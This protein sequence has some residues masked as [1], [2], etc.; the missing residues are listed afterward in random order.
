MPARDLAPPEPRARRATPVPPP[1]PPP[2][3]A[4]PTARPA[5][6][7]GAQPGVLVVDDSATMRRVFEITL[8]EDCVVT[9]VGSGSEA[10]EAARAMQPDLVIADLSLADK[11]GYQICAEL[12]GDAG[13]G[14]VPVLL[15]HGPA[16]QYDAGRAQQVQATDAIAK[17]FGT[18]ELLDKVLE[19]AS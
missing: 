13:L 4:A 14:G 10:L 8:A 17:P 18:Q 6:A 9:V 12:R 16:V 19:L 1:A 3:P 15:C 7:P 5:R 11:D 2:Q